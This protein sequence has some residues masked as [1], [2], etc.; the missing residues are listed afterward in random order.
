MLKREEATQ[1]V[2]KLLTGKKPDLRYLKPSVKLDVF[3]DLKKTLSPV[4]ERT[5]SEE[6]YDRKRRRSTRK[7]LSTAASSNASYASLESEASSVN[8]KQ[9]GSSISDVSVMPPQ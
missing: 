1:N 3:G 2:T 7:R 8:I 5:E 6:S 9:A 4:L